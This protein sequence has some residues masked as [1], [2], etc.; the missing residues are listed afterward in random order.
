MVLVVKEA[1]ERWQAVDRH[2]LANGPS[3]TSS[4]HTHLWQSATRTHILTSTH[5]CDSCR[6]P[7]RCPAV[8]KWLPFNSTLS[9]CPCHAVQKL[10]EGFDQGTGRWLNDVQ[11]IPG[12]PIRWS[13]L[14]PRDIWQMKLAAGDQ[15]KA[16]EG[17]RPAAWT[18]QP[19]EW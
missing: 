2:Q 8:G 7:P 18:A 11:S 16:D 6:Y 10:T 13:G 3:P 17:L 15:L 9:H 1:F 14:P 19:I 12:L 4:T 5:T